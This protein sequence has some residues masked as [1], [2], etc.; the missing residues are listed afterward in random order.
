MV[1]TSLI[2]I[3]AIIPEIC[4]FVVGFSTVADLGGILGCHGTPLFVGMPKFHTS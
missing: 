1:T 4:G 2:P 3:D